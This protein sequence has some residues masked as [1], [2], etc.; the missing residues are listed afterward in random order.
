M[1]SVEDLRLIMYERTAPEQP[2]TQYILSVWK[3]SSGRCSS[4]ISNSLR[5]I[6]VAAAPVAVREAL[7]ILER[8]WDAL[9]IARPA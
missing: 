9:H 8:T 5:H 3:E 4:V 6:P 2:V 7:L 1:I